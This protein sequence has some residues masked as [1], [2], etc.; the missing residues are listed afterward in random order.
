MKDDPESGWTVTPLTR[1][2]LQ[3]KGQ[4]CFRGGLNHN[5]IK[6]SGTQEN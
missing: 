3:V 2:Q 5:Q 4:A 1:G 6:G